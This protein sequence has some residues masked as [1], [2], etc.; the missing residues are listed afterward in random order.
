[1]GIGDHFSMMISSMCG[2]AAVD[3]EQGAVDEAGRVRTE[4]EHGARHLL[5]PGAPSGRTAA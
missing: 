2:L 1:V 4:M 5:G 3:D